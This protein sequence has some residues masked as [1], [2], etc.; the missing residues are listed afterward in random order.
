VFGN[1][2]ESILVF[3]LKMFSSHRICYTLIVKFYQLL[4]V[5]IAIIFM[6]CSFLPDQEQ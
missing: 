5:M 1:N 3:F 2:F 4:S 6:W